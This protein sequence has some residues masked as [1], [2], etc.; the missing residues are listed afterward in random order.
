[1]SGHLSR[2]SNLLLACRK[3]S[4]HE[5]TRL[6]ETCICYVNVIAVL[7]CVIV[8]KG[9]HIS[10]LLLLKSECS[11]SANYVYKVYEPAYF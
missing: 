8:L 9:T 11:S 6:W 3:S 7:T 1:M 10:V 2:T 4:L 5:R